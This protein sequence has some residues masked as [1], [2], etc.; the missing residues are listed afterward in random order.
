M[1]ALSASSR[2]LVVAPHP[3]DETLA[4]GVLIQRVLAAGGRVRVLL[5]TDGDDNPWPQRW[6]ERRWTIDAAS[7][8]RWGRRRRGEVLRAL[9]RL[10]VPAA[11]LQALGWPDMGL[12]ARLR[13]DMAATRAAV[14]EAVDD[15]AP[16]LLALPALGDRHPDHAAAHVMCR[17]A[18]GMATP[19]AWLTYGVHGAS[20]AGAADVVP[21]LPAQQRCK[22]EALAEHATQMALSGRRM[23]RLAAR[24]ERFA[25]GAD[26][27]AATARLPWRPPA[28]L[29]PFLRLLVADAS[30]ATDHAWRDAVT[31]DRHG[32]R[33]ALA[34]PAAGPRFAK[35][36]LDGASPWIFDHW[37]WCRI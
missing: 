17:L 15:F 16:T 10:G 13:D 36:H 31:R 11:A 6:L 29:Q 26:A 32:Y 23:R 18:L 37:G 7:R 20:R 8:C 27:R 35:L 3:D 25:D 9:H 21:A 1:H 2:L 28:M 4:C 5:L 34:N 30:G 22:L 33:L 19:F 12:T 24:T 14:A